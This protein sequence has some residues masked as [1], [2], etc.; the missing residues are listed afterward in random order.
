ME[1]ELAPKWFLKFRSVSFAIYMIITTILFMVFYSKLEFVQRRADKNRIQN[2]KSAL[3]LEDIDFIK[4]V[5]DLKI[6]YDESDLK[7][8]EKEVTSQLKRVS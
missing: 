6:D 5:N 4:M 7:E 2:I 1:R 3:E 8:I